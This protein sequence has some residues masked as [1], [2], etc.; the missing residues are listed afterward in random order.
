MYTSAPYTGT[1]NCHLYK[2]SI[3][4]LNA[5][6]VSPFLCDIPVTVDILSQKGNLFDSSVGQLPDLLYDG[7]RG[8]GPLTAARERYYA[9]GT[10][11]VATTHYGAE[12]NQ[13]R[14]P[15]SS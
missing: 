9:I 13:T 11:I 10:H 1:I 5:T 8:A 4:T 15:E 3:L 2:Q 14:K 6:T 7:L 12:G